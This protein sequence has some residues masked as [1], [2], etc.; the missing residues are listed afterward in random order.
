MI[1]KISKYIAEVFISKDDRQRKRVW[2]M[3]TDRIA[4]LRHLAEVLSDSPYNTRFEK[5]ELTHVG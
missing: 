4:E 2:T 5:R 1:L 3:E